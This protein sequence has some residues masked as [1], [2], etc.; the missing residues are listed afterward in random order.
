MD[1]SLAE[2]YALALAS[3]HGDDFQLE[4]VARLST[5]IAGV[6]LVPDR[7]QGDG[8]VDCLS[9]NGGR[10]YCCY[11]LEPDAAKQNK[12][13]SKLIVD[14]FSDDLLRL[15]EL[16]R[17]DGALVY[18]ENRPLTKILEPGQRIAHIVLV[19]NWFSS[20]EVIGPLQ[21]A[22]S[23]CIAA[24]QCRFVDPAVTL[25]IKGPAEL[26]N[27]YAVDEVAMVRIQQRGL[28][29]RVQAAAPAFNPPSNPSFEEK[30]Q[31]LRVLVGPD[32]SKVVDS[33]AS[34]LRESWR[35][36]LAFEHELDQT[37]PAHHASLQRVHDRILRKVLALRLTPEGQGW[38]YL[39]RA[40]EIAGAALKSEFGA[41][42]GAV[43]D[44]VAA[45][46]IARLIGECPIDWKAPKNPHD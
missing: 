14:K 1:R 31:K 9:H 15:F 22:L 13:K 37:L 5:V 26:A 23:A 45:G 3:L 2:A 35:M 18:R 8:G 34:R 44:D 30:V 32:L 38:S 10:A 7:P 41:L 39:D 25:V 28:L 16:E 43:T 24:S 6:Q 36:N 4:V 29:E 12:D 21:S 11:G 19:A 46:E 40:E 42:Y 33:L 17:K 27:E 20:H